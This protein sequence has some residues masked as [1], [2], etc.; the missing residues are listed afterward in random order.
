MRL[1]PLLLSLLPAACA[2]PPACPDGMAPWQRAELY[3]GTT[4]V[5]E[6]AWTDFLARS[7]TPR[8]PEGFTVLAGRGQWREPD[9]GRIVAESSRVLVVLAPPSAER[10][11]ALEEI[12][13]AYRA[14][15]AQESVG[16]ALSPAC[17]AF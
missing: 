17:A 10:L 16:L 14:R 11:A 9:S 3:F 7:V 6:A 1:L 15:F 8:F 2:A 4:G 13:T 12:R 5:D